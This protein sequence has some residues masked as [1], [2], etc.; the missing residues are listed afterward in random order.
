MKVG[1]TGHQSLPD[2]A[3]E[4]ATAR[5]NELLDVWSEPHG[6]TALAAGSDQLFARCL[7][8]RGCNY[9]LIVPSVDY[10]ETFQDPASLRG[11]DE[12]AAQADAVTELPYPKNSEAAFLCAGL[13][14]AERSDIMVAIWD[15]E[16]AR[17]LGGTADVVTYCRK[18]G[19]ALE[20]IWPPGV[21]R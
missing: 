20:V 16:P 10:R 9:D 2:A 21:K 5:V 4:F 13:I 7:L 12:L 11:Y 15:G 6:L 19:T 8:S 17:G 3:L 14:I 1:I 18:I